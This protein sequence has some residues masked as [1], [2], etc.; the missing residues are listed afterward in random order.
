MLLSIVLISASV[1][2][3]ADS[4]VDNVAIDETDDVISLDEDISGD[5]NLMAN[6]DEDVLSDSKTV[7]PET[8]VSE[9]LS[10]DDDTRELNYT[11]DELIFDGTFDSSKMGFNTIKINNPITLTGN[12]AIFKNIS[13]FVLSSNVTIKG[14]TFIQNNGDEPISVGGD[15]GVHLD[16]ITISNVNIDYN[17]TSTDACFAIRA[18]DVGK[19]TISDSTIK[20]VGNTDG[21]CVNNAIQLYN[22]TGTIISTNKFDISIPSAYVNWVEEPPGSWNYVGYP[23]TEGIVIEDSDDVIFDSNNVTVM[24]NKVV[25]AYDTIYTIAFKN[26]NNA[27]ITNNRIDATGKTYIYGLQV[28]GDDFIIRS[29]NITSTGDYYANGI[30]IEGPAS[31]V[32]EDNYLTINAHNSAYAIYSGMNGNVVKAN[33]TGNEIYGS[34]YNFFGMSI[35]DEVSVIK[36]NT[37][38]PTGNYTTGIAYIGSD[39][40]IDENRIVLESSEMGNESIWEGF[41]VEAVGIKIFKG[42]ALI[43]DNVIATPGKG[44]YLKGNETDAHLYD[45]FI[46]VVGNNDKN[47][48]AIYAVDVPA[49]H[50]YFNNIDYQGTTE[51][52]AVNNAV[53]VSGKEVVFNDNNFTLDLVSCYVPWAEIPAGSGKWVSSPISEG[54]VIR[55]AD[56][57]VFDLNNVTVDYTDVVGSYDTIYSVDINSNNVRIAGNKIVSKGKTYIYG[58]ILTGE[59]FTIEDNEI[60]AT[61]AYYANG[62]DIEGPAY[63]VVENNVIHVESPVTAY[64]IYSG[65]NGAD[66][67]AN[68]TKN[69][70]SGEAYSIFGFSLGDVESNLLG[71]EIMLD[72]NYTTGI[73]YRGSKISI[74]SNHIVLLPSEIGDESIWESFGVEAVGVKVVKGEALIKGNTIVTSGKG[75]SLTGNETDAYLYNN[76]INVVGKDDKDAYAIYAVDIPTIHVYSNYIDYQG[77]TNGTGINNAVYV[78]AKDAVF[79]YNNFT[80][81]LV[82]AYVPWNEVPAGSGNYVS[83][84]ISEGIVIRDAT[85]LFDNNTVNVQYTDVSGAYDTIYSV[86]VKSDN[87]TITKNNIISKGKT[88]IYGII[89]SGNNFLIDNNTIVSF[90]DYYANGIDVEGPANGLIKHNKIEAMANNASYPVYGAMSNGDVS[91]V[92]EDNEIYGNAYLVYGVQLGG[93]VVAVEDNNITTEGNYTV[94]IGLHVNS[95]VIED[96]TITSNASNEGNLTIWETMGTDT[97]GILI[98]SGDAKII[99]NTVKTTGQQAINSKDNVALVKDNDLE[100]KNTT[101]KDAIKGSDVIEVV[102]HDSL[103]TILVGFD[104]T[105]VYGDDSQYVLKVLDENGQPVVGKTVTAVVNN[106]TL[107]ATTDNDGMAKFDIDLVSGKYTIQASFAGTSVYEPK[108]TNNTITVSVKPT[109]F[110]ASDA[111][112]LVTAT[113]SGV[114]YN[115]VLKD[116]SGNILANKEVTLTFNGKSVNVKTDAKGEINYNIVVAKAGSYKLS[117]SFAGDDKYAAS[118]ATANIKVSKEAVKLSA[119]KKTYKAKVKTKKYTVTLKDSKGKAVKGLKVTLKVK[120]KTYKAT[121]NAK[122]KATFKIKNLKKKG[123]YTAKVNFAGNDLYNS[124]AKSVKITVKK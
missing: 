30:D 120:G 41:G 88:Y 20:Y 94:G 96:N 93:D 77:T 61:S 121:T 119:A 47:A 32:V 26:T 38:M 14:F 105:K 97:E 7:T 4:D 123:K 44:V 72:G 21:T 108:N 56:Y 11:G 79:A 37:I 111:S 99:G 52:M 73:A 89:I 5:E 106:Q 53:Y 54:I 16:N 27:V 109:A 39:V 46:N 84:P 64:A 1:A 62:I 115:I 122:G 60:N 104:L 114:N 112:L 82:S 74:E 95:A 28:S 34:A 40:T 113:K 22:C 48:Y 71:N 92:V 50:A 51:G 19:L 103:K 49:I 76:F 24:Y 35:G 70:I 42:D 43:T 45:N 31:G 13:L 33:Y 6:H 15:I 118:T 57:V 59:N 80:L 10:G 55:D 36:N 9:Y 87:A 102:Q 85:L 98:A 124:A 12:N 65:M 90:G 81:D 75:V 25:G 83:S 2:F 63:G 3:A 100:A 101:G 110:T 66:V 18:A 68:Y 91:V 8:N 86:D 23:I 69:N 117:L 29:N 58:I 67:K 78:S 116:N 17:A 107:T